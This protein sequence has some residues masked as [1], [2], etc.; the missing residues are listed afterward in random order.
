[1]TMGSRPPERHRSGVGA[2]VVPLR[3]GTAAALA[4]LLSAGI[5]HAEA[6]DPAPKVP[7]V[8]VANAEGGTVSIVDASR[9][10]VVKE[11]D[12]V[13]DGEQA[14]V[15]EDDPAH[16][17]AGQR[18]VEA[19]GG[20][21]LAQDQDVSPDGRTL[22]VS[23]GHR[24][25]VAA[26]DI[27]SGRML[28]K[29]DVAGLRADHMTISPDGRHLYVSAL[30][31]NRVQV[32]DT[33]SA[34]M[35]GDLATG[36]WPHDNHVSHDAR[37]LLNA[38]IGNILVPEELRALN[39]SSYVLTVADRA[40]LRVERRY[41]FDRGIRPYVLADHDSRMYA[42]LS[43]LHGLI[44]YDLEAGREL[45]RLPLPVDEGVTEDDYDF[46]A[47]HHGLALSG[48]ER[49]LCAAGRASDYVALVDTATLTPRAI[50]DVGDAP[51]WAA[52]GPDGRHCF[53][54]NTRQD[55]LSVIS[56]TAGREIARLPVG[57]GPK[58][59][60][61]AWLPRALLAGGDDRAAPGADHT[62]PRIR[63]RGVPRRCTRRAFRARVRVTDAS[64]LRGGQLTVD[65]RRRWTTAAKRYSVRIA[66]QGLSAG[67]HVLRVVAVDRNGNRRAV[68]R[69]FRRCARA[70]AA[71]PR[72]TG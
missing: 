23:R 58:Q 40:T 59:I 26:F 1:M 28:W 27:A 50:V 48:D 69:V 47:P 4:V 53:V 12:V 25:D 15:G 36:E 10:A 44:E 67:R 45:R 30:T 52:T 41:T 66:A 34:T 63:V 55:T 7:V 38:S 9:L 68:R 46:E 61:A 32:V 3:H 19:A 20:T 43:E 64:R 71:V 31:D 51:G 11:L 54:P 8:L 14:A 56:Y 22:Y 33:R 57:D 29:V 17:L 60:E 13:P 70:R 72:F 6:A 21:N 16:A 2:L 39:P 42:Q 18:L 37:R 35:V 24:G 5:A 49:T 65:G 62:A